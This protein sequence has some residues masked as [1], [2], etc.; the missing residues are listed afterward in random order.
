M[1]LLSH[2]RFL[3]DNCLSI[4]P[5]NFICSISWLRRFVLTTFP[6]KLTV[7]LGLNIKKASDISFTFVAGYTNG[8]IYYAPTAEQLRN[9]GGA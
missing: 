5:I 4:I 2:I 9:M 8:Y 7:Q 1:Q 3:C 6:G